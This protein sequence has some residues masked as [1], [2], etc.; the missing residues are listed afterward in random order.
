MSFLDDYLS[1]PALVGERNGALFKAV[2]N[3]R[4]AGWSEGDIRD[5]ICTKAHFDGLPMAEVDATFKSAMRSDIGYMGTPRMTYRTREHMDWDS[6][7]GEKKTAAVFVSDASGIPAP[8]DDWQSADLPNYLYALFHEGERVAYNC[9]VRIDEGRVIPSGKGVYVQTREEIIQSK[10]IASEHGAWIRINPMD[11]AGCADSNVVSFRHALVESD[12]LPVPA[13]LALIRSLRL[14]CAAIVHSGGKSI[15][16][17]V[18]VDA[19]SR[20]EYNQRVDYLYSILAKHGLPVD[21]QNRNPSRLS[22]MPGVVRDGNPQYLIDAHTGCASWGDWRT[23]VE[24][25]NEK[26][27]IENMRDMAI[28]P[29]TL[30]PE[31]ISGILR[32]GHKMIF[33]APSKSGKSFLM[34]NLAYAI[35]HGGKWLDYQCIE[36]RVL[37][38]NLEVDKA[39]LWQR[40]VDVKNR[41]PVKQE[42]LDLWNLRGCTTPLDKLSSWVLKEVESSHYAAIILDP[43]YKTITGDENNAREMAEFLHNLDVIAGHSGAAVVAV[44]HFSKGSQGKK[45]SMDRASGS[46]VFARDPDAMGT[47][48]PL[49]G[50]DVRGFRLE[51]TLREFA[52]PTPVEVVY[53]WPLHVVRMLDRRVEGAGGRPAKLTAEMIITAVETLSDTGS[54]PMEMV[55]NYL[56]V[57]TDTLRRGSKR[58][59]TVVSIKDS[60]V[61]VM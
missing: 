19:E 46:G 16:A 60:I 53:E 39:S 13:Q 35:S 38:I 15:H 2:M 43:L 61:Y 23:F 52:E 1:T 5:R 24:G 20:N 34:I 11:G 29:P 44:H 54:A 31:C 36:G 42:N 22:R 21:K 4:R 28:N 47:M 49:E 32:R 51:W 14:P 7:I 27:R 9:S 12:K 37:Y 57:S 48:T 58:F 25:L 55:A 10:P 18:R 33:S 50:D 30:A 41:L 3:A 59:A 17:I 40:L 6:Y 56:H 26:P 45:A 8:A